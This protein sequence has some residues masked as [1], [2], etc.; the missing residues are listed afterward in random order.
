MTKSICVWYWFI[1][2]PYVCPF[3]KNLCWTI[4]WW[5][6]ITWLRRSMRKRCNRIPSD[7][8]IGRNYAASGDTIICFCLSWNDLNCSGLTQQSFWLTF[9]SILLTIDLLYDMWSSYDFI[10]HLYTMDSQYKILQYFL[11]KIWL[12]IQGTLA[13]L[14]A[15]YLTNNPNNDK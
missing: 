13:I 2:L 14:S 3:L 12:F 8:T 10:Y 5:Q 11:S 7:I 1:F 15:K 6:N 4:N 9:E